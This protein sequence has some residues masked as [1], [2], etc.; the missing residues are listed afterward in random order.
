MIN[1]HV[2]TN[3]VPRLNPLH[4][5]NLMFVALHPIL[6]LRLSNA[7]SFVHLFN[8]FLEHSVALVHEIIK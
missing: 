7:Q 4:P 1:E 2:L 5:I 8:D 3:Q 6:P